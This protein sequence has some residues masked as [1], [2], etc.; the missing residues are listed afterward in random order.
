M[1]WLL[2]SHAVRPRQGLAGWRQTSKDL[3]E[4]KRFYIQ[5]CFAFHL[6]QAKHPV[7]CRIYLQFMLSFTV[8]GG[9]LWFLGQVYHPGWGQG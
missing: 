3:F 9:Y 8:N 2:L 4:Q 7:R 6:K 1:A 5:Q